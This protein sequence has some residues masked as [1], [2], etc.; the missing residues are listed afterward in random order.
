MQSFQ[1]PSANLFYALNC[2]LGGGTFLGLT[3][4]LTACQTFEEA[5]ALAEQGDHKNVDKLV[6]DIYGGDYSRFGL[7]SDIVASS[8]GNMGSAERR[9][10][11]KKEDLAR[12][13]LVMITNN[14]GSIAM[15]CARNEVCPSIPF[16]TV[17]L[18]LIFRGHV[19]MYSL[20]W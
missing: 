1:I 11:A 6:K 10:S 16:H 13:V 14:I 3:T 18:F 15:M 7:P 12:A 5:I 4:L 19:L 9:A 2:S 20:G 8:F 17:F